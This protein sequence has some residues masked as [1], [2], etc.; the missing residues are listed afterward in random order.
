MNLLV[1]LTPHSIECGFFCAGT[2]NTEWASSP[3]DFELH[4][5]KRKRIPLQCATRTLCFFISTESIR[6]IGLRH[7]DQVCD[8]HTYIRDAVSVLLAHL[9]AYTRLTS[10]QVFTEKHAHLIFFCKSVIFCRSSSC[11]ACALIPV[12]G[13]Q[14]IS[15]SSDAAA[16]FTLLWSSS[17]SQDSIFLVEAS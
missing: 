14:K 17:A 13:K 12:C 15:L 4:T 5:G 7:P 2:P 11:C 9:K 16:A 1:N 8:S 3:F 6:T 10:L